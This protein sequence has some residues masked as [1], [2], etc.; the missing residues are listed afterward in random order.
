MSLVM[1]SV[2]YQATKNPSRGSSGLS[3]CYSLADNIKPIAASV[4]RQCQT[5]AVGHM[6]GVGVTVE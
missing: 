2:I 1:I 3:T 4:A 5:P 6:G